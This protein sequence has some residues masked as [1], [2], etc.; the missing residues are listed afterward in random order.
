MDIKDIILDLTD[1]KVRVCFGQASLSGAGLEASIK[2]NPIL[3]DTLLRN[4]FPEAKKCLL[5]YSSQTPRQI[6]EYWEKN[7]H[8]K[9]QELGGW[10]G[11]MFSIIAI[12][13]SSWLADVPLERLT[14]G[15]VKK[16]IE[17]DPNRL[18]IL[19]SYIE[20]WRS[21]LKQALGVEVPDELMKGI[22]IAGLLSLGKAP[23]AWTLYTTRVL[24]QTPDVLG[25]CTE[26][27]FE[28]AT[29]NE[30]GYLASWIKPVIAG[31]STNIHFG[32]AAGA[33]GF[34]TRGLTYLQI[35]LLHPKK[36]QGVFIK[37]EEYIIAEILKKK[38]L[39]FASEHDI[40]VMAREFEQSAGIVTDRVK[41]I[42]AKWT[43]TEV[44]ALQIA[45][46]IDATSGCP[47]NV[48]MLSSAKPFA[49]VQ[50][51]EGTWQVASEV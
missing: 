21:M 49:F 18:R 23:P 45:F 1:D 10:R 41:E 11:S 38:G 43:R 28:Q 7:N 6:L 24:G 27:P 26:R 15:D 16:G 9:I 12:C 40:G 29:E 2:G 4:G 25:K 8:K 44:K 39:V 51:I 22:T 47:S 19:H 37:T 20:S 13:Q 14:I 31:I 33:G 30:H 32:I 48:R 34:G 42:C 50:T 17:T 35:G 5:P 46:A 3:E 36:I